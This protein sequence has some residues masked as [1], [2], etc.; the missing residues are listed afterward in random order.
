MWHPFF[1]FFEL[2]QGINTRLVQPFVFVCKVSVSIV[3][4]CFSIST[5]TFVPV[6]IG[7]CRDLN[8]RAS[9]LH[10][11]LITTKINICVVF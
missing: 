3:G 11:E 1:L 6:D 10:Y 2:G 5:E 7:H 9:Y 4:V 8:Y